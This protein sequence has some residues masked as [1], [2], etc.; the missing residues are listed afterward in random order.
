MQT[1]CK[2]WGFV[3]VGSV[4]MTLGSNIPSESAIRTPA[5]K[6]HSAT[7]KHQNKDL[8]SPKHAQTHVQSQKSQQQKARPQSQNAKVARHPSR[9][10][11]RSRTATHHATP[12]V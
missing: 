1:W 9:R 6:E 10:L 5:A 8:L 4:L 12:V 11:T 3:A 2:W 7:T